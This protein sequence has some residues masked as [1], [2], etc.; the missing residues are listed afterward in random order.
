MTPIVCILK[1]LDIFYVELPYSAIVF[2]T[3]CKFK[4]LFYCIS[5]LSLLYLIEQHLLTH[6]QDLLYF[7]LKRP[8]DFKDWGADFSHCWKM[9]LMATVDTANIYKGYRVITGIFGYRILLLEKPF[10]IR[11]KSHSI[12][13][14]KPVNL[15]FPVDLT[16]N[17]CYIYSETTGKVLLR[18][19]LNN[20]QGKG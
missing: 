13:Q 16:G 8:K 1:T 4:L 5:F 9:F 12:W 19:F 2:L 14:G 18:V 10:D 3:I 7:T 6:L 17:P 15:H 11:R 20:I